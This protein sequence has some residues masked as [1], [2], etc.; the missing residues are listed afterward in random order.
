MN[1]GENQHRDGGHVELGLSETRAVVW[2]EHGRP[3]R[4]NFYPY[5]HELRRWI[6]REPWILPVVV[7]E[8]AYSNPY[9]RSAAALIAMFRDSL[10]EG[11]LWSEGG[12]GI[13]EGYSEVVRV[14]YYSEL[15]LTG[16]RIIE[17]LT[18]QL[19]FCTALEP[20]EYRR[21][22]LGK[23]LRVDCKRC[24]G[25]GTPHSISLLGSLAHMYQL[26]AGYNNCLEKDLP[27]LGEMRNQFV[28]HSETW[29]LEII[30]ERASRER[31]RRDSID[32][33]ETFLHMLEH[34]SEIEMAMRQEL[35]D[36]IISV[37]P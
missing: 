15:V 2:S 20:K 17:C 26:C 3:I 18:K 11:A 13:R 23:L 4:V 27:R 25:E 36:W 19:L 22:T 31:L 35:N 30:P 9:S 7:D 24:R 37:S 32:T 5:A 6:I 16:V 29:K 8:A 34:V 33:G 10:N 12:Q 14:R 28:A 21:A 1:E